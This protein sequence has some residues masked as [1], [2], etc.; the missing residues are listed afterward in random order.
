[1]R[2]SEINQIGVVGTGLMGCQIVQFIAQNDFKVILKSR[3]KKSLTAAIERI[4]NNLSKILKTDVNKVLQ[5][6]K[7]TTKM[8]DLSTA[9]IVIEC[10]IEDKEA[11]QALFKELSD[12]CP[13]STIL[14]TNT[15]C[16]SVNDFAKVISNSSRMIGTHFFNPVNK[17]HLVEIVPAK[18]TS[19]QTVQ[20]ITNFFKKIG[21]TPII[22]SDTPGFIVNRLLF[23]MINEAGYLLE[24]GNATVQ[25]IDTA[26]K[27]GANVPMGPFEIADLVGIDVT[28]KIIKELNRLLNSKDPAKIFEDKIK[29]AKL[30]RKTREGF[31]KY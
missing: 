19:E 5:K 6:I 3:S 15:S 10:I 7:R 1:M 31:Y 22:T 14:A 21:K 8:S 27:L 4:G 30:G 18:S 24:E 20:I 13:S 12:S 9:D 28:Y 11:K 16:L 29:N 23:P 25:K 17:T 26:M 2:K